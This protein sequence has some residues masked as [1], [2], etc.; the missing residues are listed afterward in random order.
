MCMY[1]STPYNSSTL[2]VCMSVRRT[3]VVHLCV[4]MSVRRT[5]VVHHIQYV[6]V[7]VCQYCSTVVCMYVSVRRTVVVLCV[8]V[9]VSTPYSSS[10]SNAVRLCVCM[11]V[12]AHY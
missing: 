5:V 10:K 2:C 7:Y 4:C 6:Y 3:V 12:W 8:Y 9:C 1:V 11:S